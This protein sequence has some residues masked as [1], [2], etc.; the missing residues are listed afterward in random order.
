M[1]NALKKNPKEELAVYDYGT[2]AGAGFDNESATDGSPPWIKLLQ[3]NS[4]AVENE[5]PGAVAGVFYNTLSGEAYGE[6]LHCLISN[7]AH[8]A[9]EWKPNLA[10][11]VGTHSLDSDVWRNRKGKFPKFSID[12]SQ[13]SN[14]LAEVY[15]LTLLICKKDQEPE[16]AL[17]TC[18]MKKIPVFKRFNSRRKIVRVNG[19]RPPLWAFPLEFGICPD[20]GPGGKPLKGLTIAQAGELLSPDDPN[21]IAAKALHEAV[22]SGAVKVDYNSQHGDQT[23]EANY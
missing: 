23:E 8:E 12:D 9:V 17:F 6:K 5:E 16:A 20:T 1:T 11:F 10:G 19:Q 13:D 14:K 15:T 7:V 4:R 2:D 21:Y 22:T 3:T 18:D